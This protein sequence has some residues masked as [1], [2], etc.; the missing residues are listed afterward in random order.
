VKEDKYKLKHKLY[1]SFIDNCRQLGFERNKGLTLT[2]YSYYEDF[3]EN[4]NN[5]QFLC[6]YPTRQNGLIQLQSKEAPT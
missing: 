3:F 4:F 2:R 5:Y 6:Y 1:F